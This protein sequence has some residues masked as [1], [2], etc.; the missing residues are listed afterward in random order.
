MF[1]FDDFIYFFQL[2]TSDKNFKI[3]DLIKK[4]K[5]NSIISEL[6]RLNSSSVKEMNIVSNQYLEYKERNGNRLEK[7][8]F[9]QLCDEDKKKI[10]DNIKDQC[11]VDADLK[12][13][14]F[15]KSD[16]CTSTSKDAVLGK[17]VS[18]LTQLN[19]DTSNVNDLFNYLQDTVISKA[20]CEL[21]SENLD[22]L[23]KNQGITKMEFSKIVENFRKNNSDRILSKAFE[24][25]D[26]FDNF[27]LKIICKRKISQYITNDYEIARSNYI[28]KINEMFIKNL[29]KNKKDV[30][31][32]KELMTSLVFPSFI[33]TDEDKI[34][35]II[36]CLTYM[37]EDYENNSI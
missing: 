29:I 10:I 17:T 36:V 9:N 13:V 1:F 3:S 2:K 8:C 30:N 35:F 15:I 19:I 7:T 5:G 37:E 6:Y 14:F 16:L 28:N 18:L 24:K 31:L 21:T 34:S 22:N 25:L 33:L 11:H 20:C 12:K 26:K 27:S 4:G 23:I 32:I